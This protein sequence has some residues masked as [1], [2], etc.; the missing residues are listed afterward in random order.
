[1]IIGA[2]GIGMF[3]TFAAI[4]QGA[5]VT[6]LDIDR[7]RLDLAAHIGAHEVFVP[8]P[9]VPVRQMLAVA[10]GVPDVVYEV[11]GKPS[12]LATALDLV[13]TGGRIVA[14][15]VQARPVEVPLRDITLRE[16][17]IIG[18]NAHVCDTDLP[19]ALEL[20]ASRDAGW[21]DIAPVALA[22]DDLVAD[23]LE[24][25]ATGRSE[26]IKTLVDPWAPQ[27]RPTRM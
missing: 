24:P 3:I 1:V 12:G 20:L 14:V 2:G 11:T 23:G 27:T 6:V 9:A 5:H 7:Q 10:D 19:H 25:L 15:G 22:L 26:R 18:T 8:D 21:S 16:I 17:E 4:A 13:P